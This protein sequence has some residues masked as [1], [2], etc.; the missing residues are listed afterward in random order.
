LNLHSIVTPAISAINPPVTASVSRSTGYTTNADG[1]RVPTYSVPFSVQVQ[2]QSLTYTDLMQLNGLNI[3]GIRRAIYL[4]G[5]VEGVV[6]VAQNGG[7]ILTFPSGTFPEGNVWLAA[8]VLES[9]SQ[10]GWTKIAIVLQ[11][12]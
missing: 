2:A 9:W 5:V 3:Q 11:D 8:H 4:S 1:S 7:D 6:R 10:S 12:Q